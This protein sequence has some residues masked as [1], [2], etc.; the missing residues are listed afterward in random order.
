MNIFKKFT[1][2]V[3]LYVKS[4]FEYIVYINYKIMMFILEIVLCLYYILKI[5]YFIR[6]NF[7]I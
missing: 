2:L 6:E 1:L 3:F 5:F 7:V 4:L